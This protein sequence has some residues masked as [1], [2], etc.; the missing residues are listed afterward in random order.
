[1]AVSD[2]LTQIV[3]LEQFQA[4]AK[5]EGLPALERLYRVAHND[6]GQALCVRRFLLG[7]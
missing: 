6:T 7:L 1:M 4:L 3:Q 5:Q 2:F